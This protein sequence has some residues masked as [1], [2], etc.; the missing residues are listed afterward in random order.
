MASKSYIKQAI[1]VF[2][3]KNS[4]LF[5]EETNW[6]VGVTSDPQT[7]HRAHKTPVLWKH[8]E[9]DH[10]DHARDIEKHF[11]ERG[12]RGDTGGGTRPRYIY[13]YKAAGP[14]SGR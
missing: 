11:L 9:A 5:V 10:H 6:Y 4:V 2:I 13:V 3:E 12:F 1:K 14:K 8:W 7:R